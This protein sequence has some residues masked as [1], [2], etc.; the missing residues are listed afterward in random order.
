MFVKLTPCYFFCISSIFH[1]GLNNQ[2]SSVLLHCAKCLDV[3]AIN[4]PSNIIPHFLK[5]SSSPV[6]P[7]SPACRT[8]EADPPDTSKLFLRCFVFHT[9]VKFEVSQFGFTIV[10]LT[11]ESVCPISKEFDSYQKRRGKYLALYQ[12]SHIIDRP[13]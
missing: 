6:H 1:P 8:R 11:L 2:H 5:M 12:T 9:G 13:I 4:C 10:I 3:F 7:T